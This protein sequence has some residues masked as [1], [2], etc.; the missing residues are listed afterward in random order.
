MKFIVLLGALLA[1]LVAVSADRIARE[2]PEMESV[3][4]AVLTRQARE[5][6]DPAVVEDAIRKF[7]RWL[8]QKYG[9]NIHDLIDHFKH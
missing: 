9:I 5:A 1:L 8:V 2:A 3:D 7:V 6:E 4:E